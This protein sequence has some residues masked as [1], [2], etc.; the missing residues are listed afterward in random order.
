MFYVVGL[1]LLYGTGEHRVFDKA[2]GSLL[3]LA[4]AR[5]YE[6]VFDTTGI[7]YPVTRKCEMQ[8]LHA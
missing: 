7:Y 5:A 1:W 3:G 2:C 6:S 8:G 4:W